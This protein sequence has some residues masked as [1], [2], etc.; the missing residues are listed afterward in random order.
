MAAALHTPTPNSRKQT[1]FSKP[2]WLKQVAASGV[3]GGGGG[4]GDVRDVIGRLMAG[5]GIHV[6][7]CVCMCFCV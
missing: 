3:T 1:A 4:G 7:L 2:D 6:S 5:E